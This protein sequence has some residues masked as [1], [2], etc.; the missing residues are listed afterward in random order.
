MRGGVGAV[1][2]VTCT[3]RKISGQSLI[4]GDG[5]GQLRCGRTW[6]ADLPHLPTYIVDAGSLR[7]A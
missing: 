7:T 5:D 2:V 1:H 3:R 4:S 6:L